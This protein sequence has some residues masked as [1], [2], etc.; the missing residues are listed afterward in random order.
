MPVAR[1]VERGGPCCAPRQ[2]AWGT[3]APRSLPAVLIHLVTTTLFS[4]PWKAC[5]LGLY[6][7]QEIC[8]LWLIASCVSVPRDAI[9]CQLSLTLNSV[10][11]VEAFDI[12]E[13]SSLKAA[14][15]TTNE[16]TRLCFLQ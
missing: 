9:S 3:E 15:T 1:S 5:C 7:S 10:P 12:T 11:S 6:K 8:F 16:V 13:L 14:S 2:A 4:G